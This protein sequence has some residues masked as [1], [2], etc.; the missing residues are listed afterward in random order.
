MR[1]LRTAFFLT[2][3]CL[4]APARSALAQPALVPAS[5]PPRPSASATATAT[6][7]PASPPP[8]AAPSSAA[9]SS[10]PPPDPALTYDLAGPAVPVPRVDVASLTFLP[11]LPVF[12]RV[13][14]YDSRPLRITGV[15]V[16]SLGIATLFAAGVT[17]IVAGASTVGLDD[18]CP[19][20]VCFEGTS[21]ARKLDRSR[22]AARATDWLLGIGGPVVA[23]GTVMLLYSAVVER[24]DSASRYS[25]VLRAG[26]GSASLTVHF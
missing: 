9:P 20:K 8:T 24:R 26:P 16:L 13:G 10:P 3:L 14:S 7:V 17:A 6:L 21:G 2:A 1:A 19:G 18:D 22:D 12:P 23:S 11:K 5:P 25:P 4:V 15:V